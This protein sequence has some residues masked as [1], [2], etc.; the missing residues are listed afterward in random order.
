MNIF[1]NLLFYLLVQQSFEGSTLY[2][3]QLVVVSVAFSVIY[4][5]LGFSWWASFI[6]VYSELVL[7]KI[8]KMRW[9]FI[10]LVII[11]YLIYLVPSEYNVIWQVAFIFQMGEFGVHLWAY[12][13]LSE[14][15]NKGLVLPFVGLFFPWITFPVLAVSN[16]RPSNMNKEHSKWETYFGTWTR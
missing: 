16:K 12:L 6:P 5:K 10:F 8:V 13:I 15:F 3:T 9:Q 7:L 14:K 4:K 11:N 1:S 2:L